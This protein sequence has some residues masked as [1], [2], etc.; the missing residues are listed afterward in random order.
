MAKREQDVLRAAHRSARA[1]IEH[2]PLSLRPF[3]AGD[4]RTH[5]RAQG[6]EGAC[7]PVAVAEQVGQS[8]LILIE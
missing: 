2:E 7:N 1:V 3:D 8:R 4:A 6:L 5:E